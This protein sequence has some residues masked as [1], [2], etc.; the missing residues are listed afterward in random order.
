M[1]RVYCEVRIELFYTLHINSSNCTVLRSHVRAVYQQQ[2]L[3]AV[4]CVCVCLCARSEQHCSTLIK[5]SLMNLVTDIRLFGPN[6]ISYPLW[7]WSRVYLRTG[8]ELHCWVVELQYNQ[9]HIDCWGGSEMWAAPRGL[10]PVTE[11]GKKWCLRLKNWR[12][13]GKKRVMINTEYLQGHNHDYSIQKT[14]PGQ[15]S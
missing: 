8:T 4:L 10:L 2:T 6:F 3:P 5:A 13:L 12:R 15:S 14:F 1:Q 9:M 7:S 11:R